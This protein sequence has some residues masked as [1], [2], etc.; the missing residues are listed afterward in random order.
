MLIGLAA[1]AI[2]IIIHLLNR[3]RARVVDWG[4]M[5]FLLDS[6]ASRN[7]RILIEE[8][9]LMILR[10][11]AVAVLVLAMARP[12]M[13]TRAGMSFALVLGAALLAA[14]LAGAG[15]VMRARRALRTALWSLAALLL[16]GA[17]SAAAYE[18]FTQQRLWASQGADRDI[19]I[20]ID[21]SGSMTLSSNG[22]TN[23]QRAIDESRLVVQ[24]A[25]PGDAI[26]IIL[27]GPVP[28]VVAGAGARNLSGASGAAAPTYDRKET[29]LALEGLQPMGS[30]QNILEALHEAILCLAQGHNVA[31]K[32]V[33][34]TDG[35]YLGWELDGPS[36]APG[37]R[38]DA[39]ATAM[40]D[41][42]Q[43]PDIVVRTLE[44]PSSYRN[45][46]ISDLRLR[47]PLVGVDRQ[48]KVDVKVSNTGASPVEAM[49]VQMEIDGVAASRQPLE[50]LVPGESQTVQFDCA[51]PRSGPHVLR[52]RLQ[53]AS[54][55]DSKPAGIDDLPADDEAVKVVHAMR[56]LPVLL[57]DGEPSNNWP[58]GASDPIFAAL[59]P[60]ADEVAQASQPVIQDNH[61]Q[62][63]PVRQAGAHATPGRSD[64]GPVQILPSV[65]QA[66]D[67]TTIA[68]LSKYK[69]VVLARVTRLDAASAEALAK[70]V[71]AGGGL[72]IAPGKDADA[73]FYSDWKAPS[74]ASICPA[75][76]ERRIISNDALHLA[77]KTFQ[78][79]PLGWMDDSSRSDASKALVRSYWQL[80][81]NDKDSAVR[82]SAAMDNSAPLIAERR[83]GKGVVMLSAV[84]MDGLDGNISGLNCFTPMVNELMLYLC[85]T[86][87]PQLNV[88]PTVQAVLTLP[89]E[90][91]AREDVSTLVPGRV[92][93][94]VGPTGERKAASVVS[95]GGESLSFSA[96]GVDEPGLHR[97]ML[98]AAGAGDANS[99]PFA[100]TSDP[101]ESK[102]T[103]LS[104]ADLAKAAKF[105]PLTRARSTAELVSAVAGNVPGKELWRWLAL[106]AL[107]ALVAE[108]A[109][110]RWIAV[111]RRSNERQ[112]VEFGSQDSEPGANLKRRLLKGG[113][114]LSTQRSGVAPGGSAAASKNKEP[115]ATAAAGENR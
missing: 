3:R 8:L 16:A 93:Q 48:V 83:A 52:V 51:F 101:E 41:S 45:L 115:L 47:A 15:A 60:E 57:V 111:Q 30:S 72:L 95:A 96:S 34:I 36:T 27:A 65:V 99:L 69:A 23:F 98:G 61:G 84:S 19:A 58:Q 56:Q 46:A 87:G 1:V 33:V 40:K 20:I 18:H 70:Y 82:V 75:G 5:K 11:L 53:S 31:K 97:L 66:A 24:A 81:V 2:P 76:L 21:A 14:V 104:D 77:T 94:V 4:A 78:Q 100:V 54:A 103:A 91:L 35:Q 39:L 92:L 13:P 9:L 79:D 43:R 112:S 50:K 44:L 67:L 17:G 63:L 42:L 37:G 86:M 49:G 12:Y 108:I 106:A 85:R 113:P 28:R 29:L 38:W 6:L 32:I 110:T 62:D 102:L 7:R 74:G 114:P 10:C 22:K 89:L 88:P 80:R 68:D 109:L 73:A 55:A 105:V 90:G 71:L 59:S 25:K 26:S 107:L 64:I